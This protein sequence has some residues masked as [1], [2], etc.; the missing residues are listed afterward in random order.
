MTIDFI[1]QQQKQ[2]N[3]LRDYQN[4]LERNYGKYWFGKMSEQE[5]EQ[6]IT[7]IP[8]FQALFEKIFSF[9]L[10]LQKQR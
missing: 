4:Q 9:Y 7:F 6:Y 1:N 3:F 8:T 2:L 10:A 5:K